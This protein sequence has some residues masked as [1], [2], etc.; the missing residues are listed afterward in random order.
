MIGQTVSHYR[1]VDK[2]GGGGMGVVYKAIDLR[3]DRFVALKFLPPDSTRDEEAIKRFFQEAKSA[4]A[5][6]HPN[7]CTIHEI[8]E[9]PDGEVFLTMAYYDG[10]TLK[11][12]IQRGRLAVSD[13]LDCAIQTLRGLV[14]AHQ[15][16]LVHRDIKPANLMMTRE[17]VVKILDF[18]LAKLAGFSDLTKTGVTMGTAAYMAPEQVLGKDIDTRTDIWATGVVLYELLTGQRPFGGDGLASVSAILN[19]SPGPISAYRDDVPDDVERAVLKALEKDPGARY[20]SP[21]EFLSDLMVS[22]ATI[23]QPGA[24]RVTNTTALLRKPLVAIPAATLLLAGLAGA[25]LAARRMNNARWARNEAL[26]EIRRLIAADDLAKGFK[27]AEEAERFLPGDPALAQL[28]PQISADGSL[29]T[30]PPGAD[31]F[32]QEYT[33]TDD[34]W[35]FLGKTP[36]NN[37]RLPRTVLRFKVQKD[38]YETQTLASPN[39]GALLAR[40]FNSFNITPID[41]PLVP[42]G[43][44]PDMVS[45]PGGTGPVTLTGFNLVAPVTLDHFLIDR[46]E[47]TNKEYKQ[48]ADGDG[49]NADAL[50]PFRDST[51]RPGPAGW[52]LGEYPNGQDDYP[53]AGVSWFEANAYCQSKGKSLPTIFHWARAAMPPLEVGA[54]LAPAILPLSNFG[55]SGPAPVETYRGVGPY[56]TYDMAGNVR[57]WGWNEASDGR[58]WILGGAWNDPDYLFMIGNSLPPSDRSIT[59]GFRCAR[60]PTGAVS[61]RLLAHSEPASTDPR[62]AKPVSDEVFAV[63]KSQ[64]SLVK[65]PVNARLESTDTTNADWIR[66]KI[67]LDAGYDGERMTA[68]LFLPRNASPPY[69]VGV[70][71]PPQGGAFFSKTSSE[72]LGPGLYNYV[73]RSGRALVWPIYKGSFERWDPFLSLAGDDYRRTFRTRMFNWRQDL[74]RTLDV[75]AARRDVDLTRIAYLGYSFGSSTAFPLIGLEDRLKTAVLQAPGISSTVVGMPPEA[76]PINYAPRVKIPVLM[77]GSRQDYLYPVQTSQIPLFTRLGTAAADKKHVVFDGGHGQFPRS[78]LIREVLAWLDKYLGPVQVTR[79]S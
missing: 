5:L 7:I 19:A 37:V 49:Y 47:V 53:V 75:L 42:K 33:T 72:R 61:E 27:V 9:T 38:G 55:K 54:A 14:K 52:E 34:T 62:T 74:G 46:H 6:D 56:G 65:A 63:Y 58:R 11:H 15:S 60:Y 16:G 26:P 28:W 50:K 44:A 2:L 68:Y 21:S 35:R 41:I 43:T 64:Y 3:L 66:E 32:A 29:V 69:Q 23:D 31:V 8:D 10:E 77:I 39:P 71:F 70:Y 45:I 25:G 12:K 78:A 30:V 17:G 13:A 57:E 76:D 59:N 1:V 40:Q 51:G 18:G 67:S 48:F 4:S 36:L 22:K 24:L 73:V 20:G 79:P